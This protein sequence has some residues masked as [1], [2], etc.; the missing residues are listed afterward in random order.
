MGGKR[1][2]SER[3]EQLRLTMCVIYLCICECVPWVNCVCV[4]VSQP[5][6]GCL[7]AV[8]S[9]W[10]C[11]TQFAQELSLSLPFFSPMIPLLLRCLHRSAPSV[12]S[13]PD[14]NLISFFLQV[15]FFLFGPSHACLS[16][17][18]AE[19]KKKYYRKGS[20][21]IAT[22][23]VCRKESKKKENRLISPSSYL[24]ETSLLQGSRSVYM[25][26]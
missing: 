21:P 22:N 10:P 9:S 11:S 26:P 14:L 13:S 4:G 6:S 25:S 16:L 5:R 15:P 2:R 12:I 17:F 18:T 1:K 3:E 20:L 7:Q 8:H 24:T 19:G 23:L